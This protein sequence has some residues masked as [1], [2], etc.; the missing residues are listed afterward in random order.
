[1]TGDRSLTPADAAVAVRSFPRRFRAVFARP[2]DDERFEPDEV[3]RRPGPEGTTAVEHLLAAIALV[4][5]LPDAAGSAP[6]DSGTAVTALLERLETV[7]GDAARRIEAVPNDQWGSR[8]ETTQDG[9][10][11]VATR[12]RSATAV[13]ESVRR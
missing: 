10:A 2:D 8:L 6:A 11:E 7:A 12:L 13:L 9:V 5:A 4:E 3:A 1:M